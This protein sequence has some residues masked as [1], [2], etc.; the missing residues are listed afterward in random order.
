MRAFYCRVTT[1]VGEAWWARTQAGVLAAIVFCCSV[2]CSLSFAEA[3]WRFIVTCD[4]RGSDSGINQIILDELVGEIMSHDVDLVLFPGDLIYGLTVAG[5][6]E[7]EW[8]LRTWVQ[9]MKPVYDANIAVYVCRGNHELGYSAYK[10]ADPNDNYVRRWLNVFGSDA[11]PDQKLPGNGPAGEGYMTYSATHKNAFVVCLDQYAG[12]RHQSAHKLNQSWLDAELAANTKP[13]VF[14]TGHEPAFKALHYDCLGMYPAD[15]DAFWA[16]LKNAGAR[17][18]LCGHDHFYDHARVDDGDDD[19]DNDIHQYII[20][21][22]GAYP[23][24]WSGTYDGNNTSYTVHQLYHAKGYGY[25]LAEV[26]DLDVT[27]TW[28]QRTSN[29]LTDAGIY[30]PN[31]AWSYT[32]VPK[33]I[34][35]SPNGGEN[36]VAESAHLITWKTLEGVQIDYVMIEYSADYG[37]S[38]QVIGVWENTGSY[39]WQTPVVDSNQ[40]LVRISDLQDPSIVDTSDATFTIF[41]CLTHLKAD[42]NGDCYVDFVDLAI[43][44]S[45]WLKCANP[46]DASCSQK[47]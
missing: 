35:L 10:P 18:Y 3:P 24:T 23:Y 12:V 7:F 9:T 17:T 40:F 42:L 5:P 36:W 44:A 14:V 29:V 21:T 20:G 37:R 11:Y 22:A 45:D 1:R 28:I 33:P 19:P 8:Q 47:R 16:S 32:V 31:E 27:L 26:N 39:L 2:P 4:S 13:H 6:E 38:W 30:E 25:V 41:H 46:F 15:R 43:L 34:V